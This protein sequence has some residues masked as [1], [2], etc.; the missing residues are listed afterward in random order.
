[1]KAND[2]ELARRVDWRFLLSDARLG[3][4]ACVGLVADRLRSALERFALSVSD[5]GAGTEA[6]GSYDLVVVADAS[7]ELLPSASELARRGGWVYV[8]TSGRSRRRIEQTLERRGFEGVASH[9]HWPGF[10]RCAE[11]VPLD[12]PDAVRLALSRRRASVRSRGKAAVAELLMRLGQLDRAIPCASVIGRRPGGTG[13]SVSYTSAFLST[14]ELDA[15]DITGELTELLVTPTF[16]TSRHV[17]ALVAPAGSSV[18]HLVAKMPRLA[19]DRGGVEREADVLRQLETAFGGVGVGAPHVVAF[20]DVNGRP[21]LVE[22]AIRGLPLNPRAVRSDPDGSIS[23]VRDWLGRLPQTVPEL[24]VFD[25]LLSCPLHAH[26]ER[27]GA[28]VEPLVAQT[29]ALTEPLRE[30]GFPLV[31]E[32]GDLSHPNL[33]VQDDGT[34]GVIDWELAEPHGLPLNDLCFFLAYVAAARA[35]AESPAAQ[36]GSF[37]GAFV[38]ADAWAGRLIRDEATRRGVPE[39]LIEPL[40]VATW[41]RDAARFSARA[42]VTGK[43]EGGRPEAYWR[44]ALQHAGAL[45]WV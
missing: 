16:P 15:I 6:T 30:G 32:H 22:T 36:E 43:L 34:L 35:G 20:E 9:W 18:P 5:E 7:G 21:V 39:S 12:E 17:I 44:L 13:A 41:A 4:V 2:L 27:L 37:L 28:R 25:R 10:E 14:L 19:E 38:G 40:F 23:I 29:L 26:S 8:E 31:F 24:D 11:I 3:S 45:G 33:L 1:M 42:Q